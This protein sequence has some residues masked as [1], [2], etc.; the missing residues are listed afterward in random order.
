MRRLLPSLLLFALA[1]SPAIALANGRF[2]A[3]NQLVLGPSRLVIRT[4]FGLLISD[5]PGSFSWVCEQGFGLSDEQDPPVAL[6]EQQRLLVAP[7]QG[8]WR[9]SPEACAFAKTSGIPSGELLLDVSAERADPLRAVTLTWSSATKRTSVYGSSDGGGVWK[10]RGSPPETDGIP[11]TL[12]VAPSMPQRLMLAG[13]FSSN[14]KLAGYVSRSDD[15]TSWSR[16]EVPLSDG[17]KGLFLSAI[18]PQDPDLLYA[19]TSGG[20]QDRLLVSSDGGASFSELTRVDGPMLGFALSPDGSQ[21]AIGG[22]A[23]GVLVAP[24]GSS[25]FKKVRDG[26]TSCL[27][28][29]MDGLYACGPGLAGDFVVGR[30]AG[31]A[32]WEPVL[33][34]LADVQGPTPRCDAS[35]EVAAV[36]GPLWPAEQKI[37]GAIGNSGGAAGAGGTGVNLAGQ[38]GGGQSGSGGDSGPGGGAGSSGIAA[39]AGE[40]DCGC[41]AVGRADVRGGWLVLIFG[42]C[43]RKRTACRLPA[44]PPGGRP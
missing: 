7:L 26:A 10:L 34:R 30:L 14:G 22:P 17:E 41:R 3:A 18:D 33:A 42:F 19:R 44:S 6:A 25:E 31:S 27:A 16:A 11:T 2:P 29:G 15:N 23:V 32:P 5:Q 35:S 24:R 9:S 21:V 4:T 12:D 40:G 28:W 39:P 1:F 13:S 37:L 43:R 36:C 20:A 38:G 8:L